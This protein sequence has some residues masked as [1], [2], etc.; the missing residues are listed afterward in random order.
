METL[1]ILVV[2]VAG[3]IYFGKSISTL[4][5][6]ADQVIGTAGNTAVVVADL[7]DDTVN[8]YGYEVRFNNMAKRVDLKAKAEQLG[9][10]TSLSDLD[11]LFAGTATSS[12]TAAA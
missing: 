11:A 4:A 9:E 12:T 6:A 7:T 10:Q 2:A 5:G 1:L 8:T 3:I